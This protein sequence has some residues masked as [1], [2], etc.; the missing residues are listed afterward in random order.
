[1][2]KNAIWKGISIGTAVGS[3]TFMLMKT[4]GN[5]KKHIRKNAVKTLKSV[6]NLIDDISSVV[7]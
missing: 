1:M 2:N 4:T 6:K 3:A 5:R 7:M